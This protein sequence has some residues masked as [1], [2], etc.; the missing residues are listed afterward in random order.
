MSD[1]PMK[2]PARQEFARALFTGMVF[3]MFVLIA[4]AVVMLALF[5]CFFRLHT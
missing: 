3:A 1:E 4:I 5:L 2:P